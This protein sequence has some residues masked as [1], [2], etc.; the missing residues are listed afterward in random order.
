MFTHVVDRADVG[1]IDPGSGP[2]YE[3][4]SVES[5]RRA[6][7]E[8]LARYDAGGADGVRLR[9]DFAREHH[10]IDSRVARVGQFIDRFDQIRVIDDGGSIRPYAL[11]RSD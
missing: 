3:D 1:M 10:E 2:G 11:E 8:A 7:A 6:H 9:H 5:V 4:G